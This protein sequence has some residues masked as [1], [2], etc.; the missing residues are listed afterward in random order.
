L[1]III[2]CYG[3]GLSVNGRGISELR[4]SIAHQE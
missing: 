3:R 2:I 4:T 1:L